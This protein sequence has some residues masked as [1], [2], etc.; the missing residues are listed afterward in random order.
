MGDRA[1]YLLTNYPSLWSQVHE[2][3]EDAL[4]G[5]S[6]GVIVEVGRDCGRQSDSTAGRAIK[7][8]EASTLAGDL[9]E[10]RTWI[11]LCPL[12]EDRALLIAIW[13]SRTLGWCWVSKELRME[14]NKCI[15]QWNRLCDNLQVFLDK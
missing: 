13:R 8:H 4:E 3:I 1:K 2:S 6:H 11:D 14:V 10:V 9:V 15:D 5:G 12:P 7:L